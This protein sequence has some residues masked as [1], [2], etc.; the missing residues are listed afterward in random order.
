MRSRIC[1]ATHVRMVANLV[2]GASCADGATVSM[3]QLAPLIGF[4]VVHRTNSL[5]LEIGE[6]EIINMNLTQI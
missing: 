2:P 5:S 6:F 1:Q 4:M 3:V